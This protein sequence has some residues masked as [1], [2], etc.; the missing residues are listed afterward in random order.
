MGQVKM[1]RVGPAR[2]IDEAYPESSN[3][4]HTALESSNAPHTAPES[5][6]APHTAPESSNAVHADPEWAEPALEDDLVSMDG[7]DDD[8][9]PEQVEFNAKSDIR[10]VVLKKEMKFL[11]ANVFRA[12]LREYAI[13]KPVDI[14]FKLN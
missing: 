5:S 13:K 1:G 8:Q 3:A 10:N 6:N 9:V 2:P 4:P 7:S 14:K 12:A 11:N